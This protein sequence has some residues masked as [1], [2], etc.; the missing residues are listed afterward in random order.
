MFSVN[1]YLFMHYSIIIYLTSDVSGAEDIIH[2][3]TSSVSCSL[4]WEI[5]TT[6]LLYH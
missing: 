6:Q 3:R 2:D 4:E 1:Y 5:D